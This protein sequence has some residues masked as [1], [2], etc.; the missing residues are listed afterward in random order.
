GKF[1]TKD[2]D[3][4]YGPSA[5]IMFIFVVIVLVGTRVVHDIR[6]LTAQECLASATAIAADGLARGLADHERHLAL[7]LV[8]RARAEGADS[9]TTD[10]VRALLVCAAPASD[11]LHGVQRLVSRLIPDFFQSPRWVPVV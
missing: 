10:R 5:E 8:E 1:V 11:Y 3:Y 2:N 7:G 6:P 4:F 9:A